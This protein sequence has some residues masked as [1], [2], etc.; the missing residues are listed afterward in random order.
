ME[1]EM[2]T[3]TKFFRTSLVTLAIAQPLPAM[4]RSECF[5]EYSQVIEKGQSLLRGVNFAEALI[6]HNGASGLLTYKGQR[7]YT[8][9]AFLFTNRRGSLALTVQEVAEQSHLSPYN[10]MMVRDLIRASGETDYAIVQFMGLQLEREFPRVPVDSLVNRIISDTE[11]DFFCK[12]GPDG[13]PRL[14]T[15]KEVRQYIRAQARVRIAA[16]NDGHIQDENICKIQDYEGAPTLVCRDL[17]M[18]RCTA[19]DTCP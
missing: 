3:I 6:P 9:D 4:A 16:G 12:L 19:D 14:W 5:P 18:D 1:T 13:K 7:A 11:D 2:N 10:A 15:W 17:D 8:W